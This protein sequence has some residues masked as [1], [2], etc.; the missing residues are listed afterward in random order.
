MIVAASTVI[1]V[2]TGIATITLGGEKGVFP[3]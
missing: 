1:V 2:A 3:P